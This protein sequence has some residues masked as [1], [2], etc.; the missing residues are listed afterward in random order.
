MLVHPT[1]SASPQRPFLFEPRPEL[2]GSGRVDARLHQRAD[3]RGVPSA[4]NVSEDGDEKSKG[5]APYLHQRPAGLKDGDSP[6]HF[7][8]HD[9]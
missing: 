7:E 4:A 8:E 1:W 9:A 6:R 3:D 5:E 2:P